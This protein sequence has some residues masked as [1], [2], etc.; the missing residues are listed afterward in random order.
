MDDALPRNT[1][2]RPGSY[3]QDIAVS[4]VIPLRERVRLQLR[5]EFYNLL[6]HANLIA[7][8]FAINIARLDNNSVPGVVARYGGTPRQVVVAARLEF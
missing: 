7:T 8:D 3:F 4:R 6:N 1:Y 5:A 2:R